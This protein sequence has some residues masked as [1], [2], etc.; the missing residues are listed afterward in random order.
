M[1]KAYDAIK[2]D[3]TSLELDEVKLQTLKI[4]MRISETGMALRLCA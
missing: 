1:L 2:S 4:H 3:S